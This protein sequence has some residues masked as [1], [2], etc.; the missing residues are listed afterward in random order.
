MLFRPVPHAPPAATAEQRRA[1]AWHAL[2]QKNPVGDSIPPKLRD[3]AAVSPKWEQVVAAA[4]RKRRQRANAG[5]AETNHARRLKFR[6]LT[7]E[8]QVWR[9]V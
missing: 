1:Y 3:R 4:A 6:R 9:H 5:S 2:R 8:V 7:T